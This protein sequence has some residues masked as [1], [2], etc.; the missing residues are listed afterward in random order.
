[1]FLTMNMIT[2]LDFGGRGEM[3]CGASTVHVCMYIC[4]IYRAEKDISYKGPLIR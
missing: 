4:T 3:V 1:M 2:P